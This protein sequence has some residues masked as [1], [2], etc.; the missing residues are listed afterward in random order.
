MPPF[1]RRAFLTAGA[2]AGSDTI[3]ATATGLTGSP[4]KFTALVVTASLTDSVTV[5]SGISF[6]SRRNGT[7]NP[8]VDTIAVGGTMTWVWAGGDHGIQS[9]G[10]PSFTSQAA[11]QTSGT[12]AV[13]FAAAGTYTYDCLVHGSLM[14]GRIVVRSSRGSR[15]SERPREASGAARFWGYV[16]LPDC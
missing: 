13:T 4:I 14:T 12:Y 7:S 10:T 6:T 5:D 8:A 9:T 2:T 1:W 16:P 15:Y 3:T 11:A